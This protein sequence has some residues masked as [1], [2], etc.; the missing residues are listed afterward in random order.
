MLLNVALNRQRRLLS[1]LCLLSE[2]SKSKSEPYLP[3]QP[4]FM[5]LPAIGKRYTATGSIQGS[6]GTIETVNG[7]EAMEEVLY[8]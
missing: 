4:N 5:K 8:Y 7:G 2:L 1:E 3:I 6:N